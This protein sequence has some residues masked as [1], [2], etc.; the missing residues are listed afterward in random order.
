MI[1]QLPAS[2]SRERPV[3][4]SAEMDAMLAAL[5]GFVADCNSFEGSVQ[6]L[7]ATGASS[8][9]MVV[10][11]DTNWD[12]IQAPGI[13]KA[14]SNTPYTGQGAPSPNYRM[15]TLLVLKSAESLS[16]VFISHLGHEMWFRGGWTGA[17][18][19][20]SSWVTVSDRVFGRTDGW[21]NDQNGLPRFWF[22]TQAGIGTGQGTT[23]MRG[24]GEFPIVLRRGDDND[25]FRCHND[26]WAE[27]P[28]SA[29]SDAD[30]S[31]HIATT[32]WAKASIVIPGTVIYHAGNATPV[33][34]LRCNGGAVSRTTYARLFARLGSGAIYGTPDANN[35]YLPDTRGLFIRDLDE[36][37]GMDELGSGRTVGQSQDH[38]FQ[39]HNHSVYGDTGSGGGP[40]GVNNGNYGLTGAAR[41]ATWLSTNGG[42]TLLIDNRG[43]AET[44]PRNISFKAYIKY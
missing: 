39:S 18:Q 20:W 40:V 27:L 5:P 6:V 17:A 11:T 2:P 32:E 16:Q 29:L 26:G 38:S 28:F 34:Y 36:G 25:A 13:Y 37:R 42:G 10:V 9:P 7:L 41:A 14:G 23:Y 15:G 22:G 21:I 31:R 3:Q 30:E 44:R 35:F 1:Q 19:E 43:G 8:Q 4:F 24:S 12:Q 33:G